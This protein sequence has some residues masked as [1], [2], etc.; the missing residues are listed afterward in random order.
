MLF[1]SFIIGQ[2][3]TILSCYFSYPAA[4]LFYCGVT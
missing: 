2:F 3:A 1:F 4:I